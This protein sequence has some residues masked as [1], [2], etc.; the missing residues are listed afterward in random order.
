MTRRL[1]RA[2]KARMLR[3]SAQTPPVLVFG[4]RRGG[5]TMVAD[6]ICANPGVWFSDE[7]YAMFPDRAD[8]ARKSARL[9]VPDHSHFFALDGGQLDRFSSF[10]H[11]LIAARFRAIGT[12]RRTLP[13]LRA[14]R[15]SLKLL[16]V[17][18]MLPW[19]AEHTDAHIISLIR[20]P[21]AQARSVLRQNW[22]FPL[23]AYLA[24][25]DVLEET[26]GRS[27]LDVMHRIWFDGDQWS[28]AILDWVVTSHPLRMAQG[29]RV[30]RVRYEDIV[31]GPEQFI[32]EIL[33]G[34]ARLQDRESMLAAI[35]NPSGSS[36]MSTADANRSIASRDVDKI[37]NGWRSH[38]SAEELTRGQE[39]LEMF[40]VKEYRFDLAE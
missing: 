29:K 8:F 18:W 5:S 7:P 11:D 12:A 36:S 3:F 34:H 16:N 32:D 26:F 9:F 1:L 35:L 17:P 10:T 20:H 39:I 38:C 37:L 2:A 22:G 27:Q 30:Y 24:R 40:D 19:F 31:R 14:D 28:R 13:G 23:E 15:S 4:L 33:V 6:A 21:G 25:P